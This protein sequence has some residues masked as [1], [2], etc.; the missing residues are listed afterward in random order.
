MEMFPTYTCS[1]GA[2]DAFRMELSVFARKLRGN[3]VLAGY[4]PADT[5]GANG[6]ECETL[7]LATSR[8]SA[9]VDLKGEAKA[10]T[11]WRVS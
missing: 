10:K 6:M 11:M 7:S 8:V 1:T 9:V 3:P 4:S 2:P 5:L